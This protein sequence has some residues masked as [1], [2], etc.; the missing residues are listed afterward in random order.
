MPRVLE[1]TSNRFGYDGWAV[2]WRGKVLRWT[3]CTTREEARE[4]LASLRQ[5]NSQLE[6]FPDQAMEPRVVKV[7]IEV[8]E[9]EEACTRNS[10]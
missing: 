3:T 7:V 1:H 6:M 9:I 10:P 2:R 5:A 8:K 4:A